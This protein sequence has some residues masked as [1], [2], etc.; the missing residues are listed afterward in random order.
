MMKF[1]ELSRFAFELKVAGAGLQGI[2]FIR[3]LA[4]FLAVAYFSYVLFFVV[5]IGAAD[6]DQVTTLGSSVPAVIETSKVPEPPD[7]LQ[8]ADW[9]LFGKNPNSQQADT[10]VSETPLQL[11]LLGVFLLS[12]VPENTSVIIQADDGQQKKYRPGDELPGGAT[13]K[14]V[15]YSR[16]VIEHNHRQEF[17]AL[18]RN[19]AGLPA[20]TE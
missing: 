16:V 9:H 20:T 18:E 7:L 8:I 13:L 10:A 17:L 14:T 19:K 12:Q 3:V 1:K 11:K 2:A 4:T 15:E 5:S 6:A